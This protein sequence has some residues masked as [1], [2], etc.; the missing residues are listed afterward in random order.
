VT[1]KNVSG[2]IAF[3]NKSLISARSKMQ[4][5]V[6]LSVAE[7]ELMA[8]IACVQEMIHVKQLIKSMKLKVKLPME[9]QVDNKGAKDLV[10]NWSIGG[11]TRHV[12]VRLNFPNS[13]KT[14]S[15]KSSGSNRRITSRIF[16][17]K[18]IG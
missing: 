16:N 1:R 5:C 18:F 14:V 17:K 9:I 15:L 12:G 3:L 8:L 11:R 6:T 10:N 4:E 13:K 2:Y 7:A